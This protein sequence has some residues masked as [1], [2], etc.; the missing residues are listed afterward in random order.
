[1]GTLI[2]N[3]DLALDGCRPTPLASYLK[4]L[5]ILRVVTE[6]NADPSVRGF[7]RGERFCLKT[8]LD[9]D[10]LCRFFLED[11]APTPIIAP[12]NGRAGFLEG[13][14]S[15][16][17]R[18]VDVDGDDERELSNREGAKLRRSYEQAAPAR[19]HRLR[20][21]A[22][23][24]ASLP[25]MAE[26]DWARASWKELEKR[27]GKRK[28]TPEESAELTRLKKIERSSKEQLVTALRSEV[29]EEQYAWLDTCIRLA[30]TGG[31]S[32][33]LIGGGADGSRD[34]GMA[35]GNALHKLFHFSDGSARE[36][37][38]AP[39][40]SAAVF[41][42][43]APLEDRD[44]FGHFYPGQ[45]GYNAT[46]GYEGSSPLNPWGVVLALEGAVLWSG[47]VTRRLEHAADSSAASFPF[48]VAMSRSG[49]GQ[50]S[51]ADQ[52]RAPGELWC[53]IWT[54]PTGLPEL[55][56]LFREGRLTLG[57]RTA[58]SGLDAALAVAALG[59][60]RGM[61]SFVRV[62]LYQSDAKMPHSAVPLRRHTVGTAP[63]AASL[64]LELADHWW[65]AS[66]RRQAR[67]NETPAVLRN[68]IRAVED[69][70]FELTARPQEA[71]AVQ[72]VLIAVGQL[73][74]IIADRPKLRESLRPPPRLSRRWVVAAADPSAEF[75]LAAA[76]AGLRA[77]LPDQSPVDA[78]TAPAAPIPST[79]PSRARYGL[80]MRQ[81]LARL[82]PSRP[83]DYPDWS[84]EKGGAVAIWGPRGLIDNLCA[85]AQRRL[86]ETLRLGLPDKPFSA[87]IAVSDGTA[88]PIAADSGAIAAFLDASEGFDERLADLIAGLVWVEPAPLKGT[89]DVRPL[90]FAYAALK[91][92]FSTR[93]ALA[94][95]DRELPS[96]PLP[97]ALPTLLISGRVQDALRLGQERARAS[98]LS[99]PFL[100]PH[101]TGATPR[102]P[103]TR[104]GRRLLAA[105][106]VPVVDGVLGACLD[107][108]Y[109]SD[110]ETDDD[111]A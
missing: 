92:L 80:Y 55:R 56:I 105:L 20:N 97:P 66:V 23:A 1:V 3:N 7:W 18:N 47:G 109:P 34:Y 106:T 14:A 35:F 99:T 76:L 21:A 104:V 57:K 16:G 36:G 74:H 88:V 19:F 111:A 84:T 44:S 98:G 40:L 10:G 85:I 100:L 91:P 49:A 68:T 61:T 59:Q 38:N 45:S 4:A 13:D 11:Y 50:L 71:G 62:G 77:K 75:R 101:R 79:D 86:I 102:P 24:F 25:T 41:G 46:I 31:N 81:H 67:A 32:P 78:P 93:A 94:R 29:D 63:E 42:E 6:Q 5:G 89:L 108:A 72:E 58:R 26:M 83:A 9:R 60:S 95:L 22:Q 37:E 17:Q 110:K 27:I 30:D 96:M 12:W 39:W 65:M 73:G 51:T 82:D 87:S 90:P 69:A 15:P 64:A 52:H 103:D 53:P 33:L 48:S 8:A 107:Q 54:R 28:R 70:L 2:M 43:A